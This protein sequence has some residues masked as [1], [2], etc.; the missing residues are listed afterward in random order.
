MKSWRPRANMHQE[1]AAELVSMIAARIEPLASKAM[2]GEAEPPPPQP[3]QLPDAILNWLTQLSMLYGVPFE[4]LI[5][6][7]RLLPRE[8]MRFFYIDRNWLYRLIDGALSI[9]VNASSDNLMLEAFVE[10][11]YTQVNTRQTTLRGSL[12][13]QPPQQGTN[14]EATLS[15]LLFRSIVVS[16]WPGLEVNAQKSDGTSVDILRMDHLS[17]D[18]L[19]VIFN[20]V[21]DLVNVIEPSEGLHFGVIEADNSIQIIVRG[22]GG[23]FPAGKPIESP[24]GTY[25]RAQTQFRSGNNQPDGVIDIESLKTDIVNKLNSVSAP[26]A[27]ELKAGGF[28]V[29]LVRGAGLQAF[30]LTG[31]KPDPSCYSNTINPTTPA[32]ALNISETETL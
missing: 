32:I 26:G 20:G 24:P 6:D 12:R 21:P 4:Y 13:N 29:E 2:A 10:A 5:S 28:A 18:V 11:V 1:M 25:L 16:G 19:L 17:E 8:S 22:L 7:A 15:G 9:G 3:P 30:Q 23:N 14:V 31:V 27:S